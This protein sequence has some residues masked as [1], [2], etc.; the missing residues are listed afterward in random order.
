MVHSPTL[1]QKTIDKIQ[2][3][4]EVLERCLNDANPED[5]AIAELFELANSQQISISQVREKLEEFKYKLNRLNKLSQA[6]NEK[7]TSETAILLSVRCDFALKEI[8][9]IYW[10]L[11]LD[12]ESKER[13]KAITIFFIQ[14]FN[15][16]KKTN[17]TPEMYI[18]VETLKHLIQSLIKASL[19]ANVLSEEE[20]H[21]F[22]LGDI[23]PQESEVMLTSLAS[24]KKWDQV[25]RNLA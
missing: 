20:I 12:K 21:A 14:Q 7:S 24:T 17:L 2:L 22:N 3:R 10:N 6:L 1:P 19:R 5:E 11:L 13:L 16:S 8:V 9:D 25:Y 4:L 23:T 18:I 15:E